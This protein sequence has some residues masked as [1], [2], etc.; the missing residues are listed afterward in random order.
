MM[1][2][3]FSPGEATHWGENNH[4]PYSMI[5]GRLGLDSDVSWLICDEGIHPVLRSLNSYGSPPENPISRLKWEIKNELRHELIQELAPVFE[6]IHFQKRAK[7]ARKLLDRLDQHDPLFHRTMN[8]LLEFVR[9]FPLTFQKSFWKVLEGKPKDF[10]EIYEEFRKRTVLF[11]QQ[12]CSSSMP[13]EDVD[14]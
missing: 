1:V 3:K 13:P 6:G 12:E 5:L 4:L 2:N 11:K 14:S 9:G 8:L 10:L 7:S